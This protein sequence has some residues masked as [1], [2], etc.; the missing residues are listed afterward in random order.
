MISTMTPTL[1]LA[2]ILGVLP[3]KPGLVDETRVQS[4]LN[5]INSLPS[6]VNP[7]SLISNAYIKRGNGYVNWFPGSLR[8]KPQSWRAQ[9]T[10]LTPNTFEI[11]WSDGKITKYV[12]ETINNTSPR[13]ASS[14]TVRIIAD[15]KSYQGK[16]MGGSGGGDGGLLITTKNGITGLDVPSSYGF[17]YCWTSFFGPCPL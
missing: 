17:G 12:F 14:G 13:S 9:I 5:R 8:G 4:P 15:G 3:A 11:K 6:G 1:I 10:I 2:I 16:W 7:N